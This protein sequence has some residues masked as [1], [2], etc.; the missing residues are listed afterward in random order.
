MNS[1]GV[2]EY[3]VSSML[4]DLVLLSGHAYSIGGVILLEDGGVILRM[5]KN[6]LQEFKQYKIYKRLQ[7]VN[8]TY[9]VMNTVSEFAGFSIT[10]QVNK[11]ESGLSA[12]AARFFNTKVHV[13]NTEERLLTMMLMGF[14]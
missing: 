5:S 4:N 6:E 3:Y 1:D 8:N 10:D 13:S 12:T 14:F 11:E 2:R 9:E 7:V